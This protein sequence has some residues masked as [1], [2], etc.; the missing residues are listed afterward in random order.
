MKL[1]I[2]FL[3]ANPL[4]SRRL[5]LDQEARAIDEA[6]RRANFR[7]R[8]ELETHWAVRI[9]DLQGLLLRHRPHIVHFGGH[10]S[11]A[12]EIVLQDQT[13]RGV[14]VP[15]LALSL[16][17][18]IL[19]DNIR[20]VVLNACHSAQQAA[21]IAQHIDCV[22]GISDRIDDRSSRHFAAAFYQGLAYARTV[23]EAFE[24]GKLQIAL[25]GLEE[26]NQLQLLGAADAAGVRLFESSDAEGSSA[27]PPPDETRISNSGGVAVGAGSAAAGE[28]GVAIGG[29]ADN[30]TI[31]TGD[32]SRQSQIDTGGGTYVA[33]NVNSGSGGF[34][35]RNKIVYG[36]EVAGDKIGGDKIGG[37]KISMGDISNSKSVAI[38]AGASSTY[39][40]NASTA[41]VGDPLAHLFA[42]L[43]TVVAA[44]APGEHALRRV[45][46][47]KT[48]VS[49]RNAANDKTTATLIQ[50]LVR[51]VPEAVAAIGAAFASPLLAGVAGPVTDFVLEQIGAKSSADE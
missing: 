38:G 47:L 51:L 4:D 42:P 20:C 27:D 45:E 36:D 41:H 43:V 5:A 16:L 46:A 48:E 24:L 50:D 29:N 2:L 1:K 7:D 32:N 28:R 8:F 44:K 25:H 23:K 22:I 14:V 6:L 11:A 39:A 19:K 3:A 18:R 37:D 15:P 26:E 31:I 35:G 49:K 21:A 10:G 40:E 9:D 30:S 13:G 34:I 17:F 12:S 33:G